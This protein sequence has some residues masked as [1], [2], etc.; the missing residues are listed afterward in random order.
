[1]HG[2]VDFFDRYSGFG[3]V[4]GA[5]RRVYRL[6]RRDLV[7]AALLHTGQT[8]EFEPLESPR[9][10]RACRVRRVAPHPEPA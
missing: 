7:G 3:Q 2:Y 9:G 10:P 6:H 8:V 5:D 1:M 4:V